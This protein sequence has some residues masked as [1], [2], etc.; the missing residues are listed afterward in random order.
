[1]TCKC[2]NNVKCNNTVSA[3]KQKIKNPK[4]TAFAD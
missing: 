4:N 1:M 2:K 3:K